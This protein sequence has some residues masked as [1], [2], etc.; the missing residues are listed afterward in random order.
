MVTGSWKTSRRNPADSLT[1]TR[2]ILWNAKNGTLMNAQLTPMAGP[3]SEQTLASTIFGTVTNKRVIY[4]RARGWFSGGSR[5]D[6]PL[7]HVTSVR[8]DIKRHVLLGVLLGLIGVLLVLAPRDSVDMELTGVVLTVLAVLC[9]WGSPSVC[10]NTAGQDKSHAAGP[11]WQRAQ[12]NAFVEAIRQ[13][14]VQRQ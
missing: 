14:L 3:S 9:F 5:E 7:A 13:Q 10:V 6:I 8:I 2:V 4:N 12:A 11:P 1:L